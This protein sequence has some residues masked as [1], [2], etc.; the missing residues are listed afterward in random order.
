MRVTPASELENEIDML[1]AD[2]DLI[3]R[4]I[5]QTFL[6]RRNEPY[7]PEQDPF[8]AVIED[9]FDEKLSWFGYDLLARRERLK[10]IRE[11][12]SSAPVGVR[13]S[14]APRAGRR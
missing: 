13:E 12:I 14:A 10:R 11:S 1:I 6:M 2:I 3:G 9:E 5:R 7:R 4:S 8:R